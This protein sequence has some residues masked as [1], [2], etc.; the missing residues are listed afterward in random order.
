MKKLL[1]SFMLLISLNIFSDSEAAQ[2]ICEDKDLE[3]LQ[4]AL[5]IV[6]SMSDNIANLAIQH[7]IKTNSP[8]MTK[9]EAVILIKKI[10]DLVIV[11]MKKT[12]NKKNKKN[13]AIHNQEYLNLII[14]KLADELLKKIQ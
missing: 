9:Q 1:L 2:I 12:K 7:K 14:D 10:T 8:E 13:I 5:D 4:E 11:V 3:L 6:A